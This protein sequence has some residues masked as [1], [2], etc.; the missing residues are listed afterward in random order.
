MSLSVHLVSLVLSIF[1]ICAQRLD[2]EVIN[3]AGDVFVAAACVAY[4]GAFTNT[5]REKVHSSLRHTCV[6]MHR[7]TCVMERKTNK[8]T[9][10]TVNRKDQCPAN[11]SHS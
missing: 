5:Y 7:N 4:C 9:S 1:Y 3:V 6:C 10:S 2:T 8:H 11:S